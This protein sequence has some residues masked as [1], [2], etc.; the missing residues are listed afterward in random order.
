MVFGESS[1]GSP[2]AGG[3]AAPA[4]LRH[5]FARSLRRTRA[6]RLD[7]SGLRVASPASA[8]ASTPI[9]ASS[10][11]AKVPSCWEPNSRSPIPN[12]AGSIRS[13]CGPLLGCGSSVVRARGRE[14]IEPLRFQRRLTA[15]SPISTSC[16]PTPIRC[17]PRHRPG[18]AVLRYAPQD[19]RAFTRH[20]ARQLV[21]SLFRMGSRLQLRHRRVGLRHRRQRISGS[22]HPAR[23]DRPVSRRRALREAP[24]SRDARRRRHRIQER[25]EPV[26]EARIG[27]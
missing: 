14:E 27:E 19:R 7:R 1:A 10:I 4:A 12:T 5:C 6:H 26:S 18:R 20:P 21:D 16:P 17:S 9:A 8:E 13:R 2:S 15:T 22:Q 24:F 25:S 3:P 23:F 11:W